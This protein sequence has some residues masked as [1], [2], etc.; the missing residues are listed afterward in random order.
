MKSV[1]CFHSGN[2]KYVVSNFGYIL[3]GNR[4]L[5]LRL[6]GNNRYFHSKRTLFS[7]F[8]NHSS[9]IRSF[10]PKS[11]TDNENRAVT[12]QNIEELLFL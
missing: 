5:G 10:L 6:N 4:N 11:L 9:P 2:D 8:S 1:I 3:N 7:N 12:S